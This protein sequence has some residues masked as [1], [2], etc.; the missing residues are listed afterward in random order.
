MKTSVLSDK[1]FDFAIKVVKVCKYLNEEKKENILSK[2]LL[3][4]GTAIGALIS[5]GRYAESKLDFIHKYG[6]AQ[7]ECCETEYWIK[8]MFKCEYLSQKEY[9]SLINDT[10]ELLK[11]L[12]ASILTAKKTLKK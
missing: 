4:S 3:R 6:I 2:Q 8:L 12:T 5:E 7:K 11:M 9:E 10:T 1:S